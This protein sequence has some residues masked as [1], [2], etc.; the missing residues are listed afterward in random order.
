[1][2]S[3]ERYRTIMVLLL[4]YFSQKRNCS[5]LGLS[6][7]QSIPVDYSE[8]FFLV[9]EL[10]HKGFKLIE[11]INLHC[12]LRKYLFSSPSPINPSQTTNFRLFQT[13]R[14]CRPQFQI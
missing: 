13:V 9:H 10:S 12:M 6:V 1:M 3:G 11:V 5:L 2:Y 14:G 8:R 7:F 4:K